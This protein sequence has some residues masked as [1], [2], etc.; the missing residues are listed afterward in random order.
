MDAKDQVECDQSRLNFKVVFLFEYGFR[1]VF[2]TYFYR[3]S[4]TAPQN[5]NAP[6]GYPSGG[7]HYLSVL[8]LMSVFSQSL[9]TLMR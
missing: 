2:T 8:L 1:V 3:K 7:K 6:D 4:D 9:F 5:L